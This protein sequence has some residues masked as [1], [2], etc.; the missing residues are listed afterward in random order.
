MSIAKITKDL[1]VK[2]EKKKIVINKEKTISITLLLLIILSSINKD[3]FLVPIFLSASFLFIQ[4]R[5]IVNKYVNGSGEK[6]NT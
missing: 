1:T 4:L 5:R 2:K 6:N 3:Y